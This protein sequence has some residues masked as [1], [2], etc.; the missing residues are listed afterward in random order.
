[1][2]I[3]D[4][5]EAIT[6][7]NEDTQIL[8][9]GRIYELDKTKN[10]PKCATLAK[11]ID[12]NLQRIIDG[13]E[14]AMA[15]QKEAADEEKF[16]ILAGMLEKIIVEFGIL[17]KKQPDGL[18]NAFK[19]RQVNRILKPLKEI[20]EGEISGPFLELV[21]EAEGG[22]GMSRNSYSD[23]TVILCQFEEA[24]SKYKNK[25]YNKRKFFNI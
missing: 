11:R 3:T 22:K 15:E 24:C 18:L 14:S 1:M 9:K 19:V 6:K 8:G 23:V 12:Q 5:Q 17:A 25:Y 10:H 7:I 2:D 4:I 21:Q 16:D 13:Y 20:M